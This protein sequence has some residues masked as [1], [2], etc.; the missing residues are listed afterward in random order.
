MFFVDPQT[1]WVVTDGERNHTSVPVILNT[2]DGG[3]GWTEQPLPSE[4][5]A[6]GGRIAAIFF[7]TR[8]I[9]VAIGGSSELEPLSFYTR[10]GGLTWRASEI[11]GFEIY[12][13]TAV[14]IVP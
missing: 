6:P 11:P 9:G 8:S 1:S 5:T 13:L 3:Q 14:D 4:Q 12:E 7:V 2:R 10:D